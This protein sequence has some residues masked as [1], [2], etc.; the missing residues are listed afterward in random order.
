MQ[1]YPFI[2]VRAVEIDRRRSKVEADVG[3]K[4]ELFDRRLV[5]FLSE[6]QKVVGVIWN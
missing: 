3:L 5:R 2:P 4:Q 1:K 6:G